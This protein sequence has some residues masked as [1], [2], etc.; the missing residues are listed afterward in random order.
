MRRIIVL[1]YGRVMVIANIV[2]DSSSI[3]IANQIITKDPDWR[4]LEMFRIGMG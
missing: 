2:I 4:K 1:P 3:V